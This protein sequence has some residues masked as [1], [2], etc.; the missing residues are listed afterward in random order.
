MCKSNISIVSSQI[1][2]L[3]ASNVLHD[4]AG[5]KAEVV[6]IMGRVQPVSLGGAIS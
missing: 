6:Y 3:N 4:F 2:L 1:V 5:K